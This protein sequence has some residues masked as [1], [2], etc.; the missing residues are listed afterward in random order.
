MWSARLKSGTPVGHGKDGAVR[1]V[2]QPFPEG[3]LGLDIEAARQIVEDEQL[4]LPDE[5]ACGGGPSLLSA[6]EF[7]ST[8]P[9]DGIQTVFEVVDVAF[10]H[11][12]AHGSAAGPHLF[13]GRP[14]RMLPRS[15][16]LNRRGTCD[17]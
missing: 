8:R 5:H 3:L 17:V 11:G 16:S 1:A 9:H 15:S 12:G 6:G 4:R 13:S 10:E 7:Y 14:S 2:G